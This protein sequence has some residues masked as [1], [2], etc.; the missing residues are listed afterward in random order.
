[1]TG[2]PQ[3]H[4]L[5]SSVNSPADLRRLCPDELPALAGELRDF[6]VDLAARRGGYLAE[7]LGAVELAIALHYAYKTPHDRLIWDGGQQ[8]IPHQILTGRRHRLHEA[9]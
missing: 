7:S 5:L 8:A 9:G 4:P 3:E 1:M 6:L 2:S